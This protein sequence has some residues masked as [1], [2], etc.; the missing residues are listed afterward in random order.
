MQNN[1]D[2]LSLSLSL[3]S[4]T[5]QDF[6]EAMQN[7]IDDQKDIVIYKATQIR[8]ALQ[9]IVVLVEE[10]HDQL[11]QTLQDHSNTMSKSKDFVKLPTLT[12]T[13]KSKRKP[14]IKTSHK[15]DKLV[16]QDTP[17]K[18]PTS[19]LSTNV[20][21][22]VLQEFSNLIREAVASL[23]IK[24][25][26]VLHDAICQFPIT[27]QELKE[28]IESRIGLIVM[29]KFSIPSVLLVPTVANVYDIIN[30]LILSLADL[31][32]RLQPW[33]VSGDEDEEDMEKVVDKVYEMR[34]SL[35]TYFEGML[36]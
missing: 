22:K 9:E 7:F 2:I 3:S 18:Q 30:E 15:A 17:V 28:P 5:P 36:F 4:Q 29:I 21:Q 35:K 1:D 33:G 32:P 10:T 13:T 26:T 25:L 24:S 12:T 20:I 11:L 19:S 23:V 6:S 27:I 14:V 16:L 31:L 34:T 8:N